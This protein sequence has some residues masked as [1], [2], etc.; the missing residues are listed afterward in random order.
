MRLRITVPRASRDGPERPVD[1]TWELDVP[2]GA[3]VLDCLE[4]LKGRHD[5]TLTFRASCRSAICGTCAMVANG[6]SILACRTQ[7]RQA[8]ARGGRLRLEPLRYHP[9]IRDLVVDLAAYWRHYAAIVPWVTPAPGSPEREH[10][11]LPRDVE[12]MGLAETCIHCGV[13]LSACPI[14]LSDPDYLGPA[15]LVAAWRFVNDSRDTRRRERLRIVDSAH[16][17]WRCHTVFNCAEA[18][19]KGID[20]TQAIVRLRGLIAR[21][22]LSGRL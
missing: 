18:C 12:R 11:I 14:A 8:A 20:P 21:E 9:V 6:R 7:A 16:G 4:E 10:R 3:T 2:E 13:C 15:A 1:Q 22:R 5:G 17:P 19:P